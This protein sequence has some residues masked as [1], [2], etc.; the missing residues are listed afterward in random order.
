[1]FDAVDDLLLIVKKDDIAVLAHK[2]N[3]KCVAAEIAH[4]VEMFDFKAQY[5]FKAGLGDR[6]DPAVLQVLAEQHTEGRRLKRCLSVFCRE[7]SQRKRGVSREIEPALSAPAL[8][9]GF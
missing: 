1:M 2:L 9:R 5:P 6:E 3:D 7:V 4:F 8:C